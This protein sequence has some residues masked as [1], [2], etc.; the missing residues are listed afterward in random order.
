[1]ALGKERLRRVP[2]EIHSANKLSKKKLK[3]PNGLE[4]LT[5]F[6]IKQSMLSIGYTKSFELKQ[7]FDHQ[8]DF[9]SYRIILNSTIL[10]RTCFGL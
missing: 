1:M 8:F 5:K 4:K 9:K 7:Q 3:I 6:H 10:F 2:N